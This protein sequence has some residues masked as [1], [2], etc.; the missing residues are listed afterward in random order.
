MPLIRNLLGHEFFHSYMRVFLYPSLPDKEDFWPG[1]KKSCSLYT[2]FLLCE[3]LITG[4]YCGQIEVSG[5]VK[6]KQTN[7]VTAHIQRLLIG[8]QTKLIQKRSRDFMLPFPTL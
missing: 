3:F 2:S 5:S 7:M 6:K 1:T 8:V 4:V